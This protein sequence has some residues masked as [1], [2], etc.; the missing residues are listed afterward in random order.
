MTRHH[1]R[2]SALN[3]LGGGVFLSTAT[4]AAPASAV[5]GQELLQQCEALVRGAVVAGESVT[6]PKGQSAAACWFYMGAVQ[7]L[8]ATVETEGG[9]SLIGSCVPSQTT[10]LDIVRAFVR[11]ARSHRDDLKLRATATLIP[12]LSDAYACRD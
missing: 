8:T 6:L 7:D 1:R 4:F 9:P 10:R 3:L 11:Y 2:R 5:T 12:A